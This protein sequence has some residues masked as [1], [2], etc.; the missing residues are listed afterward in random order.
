MKI[1]DKILE[2]PGIISGMYVI[3]VIILTVLGCYSLYNQLSNKY[4][5]SQNGYRY[6]GRILRHNGGVTVF[7]EDGR[8]VAI[9]D[10]HGPIEI[11]LEK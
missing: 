8:F 3:V 4:V 7:T 2:R 9:Y 10:Y 5:V 1:L 6:T 11:Q